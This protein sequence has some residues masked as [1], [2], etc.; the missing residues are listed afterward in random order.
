MKIGIIGSTVYLDKM[1]KHKAEL[2]KN[3]H[4]V[5]LPLFDGMDPSITNVELKINV[6]N[7][8]V[9]EWA[10]I[11]HIFYDA[12]SA[13]SLFDFGMAFMARK[14]IKIIHLERKTVG[15][16]LIQYE[17]DCENQLKDISDEKE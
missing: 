11:L 2:E 9:I 17:K 12:R 4:E 3:G 10:D 5:R 8:E 6:F 1:N 7:R 16:F 13:W 15:N 14:Q